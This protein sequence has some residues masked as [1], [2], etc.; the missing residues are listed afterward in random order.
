MSAD[1]FDLFSFDQYL[2]VFHTRDIRCK[3]VEH[4]FEEKKLVRRITPEVPPYVVREVHIEHA[5]A[6]T[7]YADHLRVPHPLAEPFQVLREHGFR[8]LERMLMGSDGRD[9]GG[10]AAVSGQEYAH[11]DGVGLPRC[12]SF[13]LP[14]VLP[15]RL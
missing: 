6:V 4:R 8:H 1:A 9:S 2:D 11:R 10:N 14:R 3:G 13:R 5:L 15:G 12:R 7:I